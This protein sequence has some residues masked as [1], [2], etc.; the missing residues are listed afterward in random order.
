MKVSLEDR[1]VNYYF[2]HHVLPP[3]DMI[4]AAHEHVDLLPRVW[5]Q[6]A[7]DSPLR[8]A[9][10]A[11]A[12]SAFGK[13]NWSRAASVHSV[14]LYVRACSMVQQSLDKSENLCS[15]E[16]LLAAMVLGAYEVRSTFS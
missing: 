11:M 15:D 1:A 3:V 14:P 6:A 13:A 10:L 5:A 9:V 7:S 2:Q 8:L 12:H 16:S 4:E